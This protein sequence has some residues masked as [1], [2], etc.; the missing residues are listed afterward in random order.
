MC[1]R[2]GISSRRR[3][4]SDYRPVDGVQTPFK[5]KGSSSVQTFTIVVTK[6]EHNVKVDEALFEKPAE[7]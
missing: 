3:R 1:R 6:V 7:K 5:V 4:L 2:L